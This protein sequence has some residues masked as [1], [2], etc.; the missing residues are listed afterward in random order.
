MEQAS[1]CSLYSII[2]TSWPSQP[3]FIDTLLTNRCPQLSLATTL[4]RST[5]IQHQSSSSTSRYFVVRSTPTRTLWYSDARKNEESRRNANKRW[6]KYWEWLF[7]VVLVHAAAPS[8]TTLY[9]LSLYD[10]ILQLP[11]FFFNHR[12]SSKLLL[13]RKKLKNRKTVAGIPTFTHSIPLSLSWCYSYQPL[14]LAG[15]Q[16]S[17]YKLDPVEHY[18]S[19]KRK[20]CVKQY[21]S[22]SNSD[23]EIDSIRS[24]ITHAPLFSLFSLPSGL[25]TI[26][27][28]SLSHLST[29]NF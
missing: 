6:E 8:S 12:P 7:F 10:S 11:Y 22:P 13:P 19:V 15:D 23:W 28:P 9:T 18:C 20:H 25:D 2:S 1:T 21:A 3:F 4:L 16:K 17:L 26:Q 29:F 5:T 24:S 14:Y 27:D